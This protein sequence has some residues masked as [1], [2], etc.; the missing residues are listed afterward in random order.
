MLKSNDKVER[1][2]YR[3]I[4]TLNR[5]VLPYFLNPKEI[6]L[7]C[8]TVYSLLLPASKAPFIIGATYCRPSAITFRHGVFLR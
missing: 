1:P 2:L 8:V 4:G 7:V 6:S 3:Q 5:Y